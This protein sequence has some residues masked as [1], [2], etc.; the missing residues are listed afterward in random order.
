MP[1]PA[2]TEAK[3]ARQHV[4]A[5]SKAAA[6]PGDAGPTERPAE[7]RDRADALLLVIVCDTGPLVAA[8]IRDDADNHA[9]TELFTGL[10]LAGW[11]ILVPGTVAAEVGYA[12]PH[13]R[14]W[15]DVPHRS[16]PWER[17]PG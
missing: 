7:G 15:T 13:R 3:G 2:S 14:R 16:S 12:R 17:A 4:H 11:Q 5:C 8:A 6:S 10:H 9:R 1:K